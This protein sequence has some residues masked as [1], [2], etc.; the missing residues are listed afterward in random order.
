MWMVLALVALLLILILIVII[1]MK[2][3]RKEEPDRPTSTVSV[4]GPAI[5]GD[6]NLNAAENTVAAGAGTESTI[7][8]N[9]TMTMG[10][11]APADPFAT[12]PMSHLGLDD[13]TVSSSA[14]DADATSAAGIGA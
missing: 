6:G 13:T 3:G 9:A 12:V 4:S 10:P 14:G 1:R 7:P 8:A 2:S 11:A 5:D